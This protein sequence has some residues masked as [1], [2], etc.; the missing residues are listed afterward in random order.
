MKAVNVLLCDCGKE[1]CRTINFEELEKYI[2]Q[3]PNVNSVKRVSFLC[4][5][6]GQKEIK[7]LPHKTAQTD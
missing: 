4:S 3:M 5:D 6:E 2:S 7:K 1:L